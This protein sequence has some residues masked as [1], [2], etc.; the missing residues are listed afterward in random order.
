M[1]ILKIFYV[2]IH[3]FMMSNM[4]SDE[5]YKLMNF[6]SQIIY[7][8]YICICSLFRTP[9]PPPHNPIYIHAC[10]TLSD[11]VKIVSFFCQKNHNLGFLGF[12]F[13]IYRRTLVCNFCKLQVVNEW[14][15]YNFSF[16]LLSVNIKIFFFALFYC[17][18]FI[19]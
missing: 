17:H 1:L 13:G 2:C 11:I 3:V 15:K 19:L 10:F 18:D 14:R 8:L 7:L 12:F 9:L 16:I 5:V 4:V 6:Q